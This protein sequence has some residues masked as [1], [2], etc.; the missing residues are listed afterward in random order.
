MSN[1]SL[2]LIAAA[3][4]TTAACSPIVI[5]DP[6]PDDACEAEP[7]PPIPLPLQCWEDPSCVTDDGPISM[8]QR[9]YVCEIEQVDGSFVPVCMAAT[10]CDCVDE[11]LD[12]GA[13]VEAPKHCSWGER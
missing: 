11:L 1:R 12:C 13:E 2:A 9:A 7:D 8:C 3:V 6:D 5:D 4:L 10:S